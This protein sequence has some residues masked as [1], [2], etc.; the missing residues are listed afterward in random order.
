ME[1]AAAEQ[2]HLSKTAILIVDD[3]DQILEFIQGDLSDDYA[4]F[5]A[6]NGQGGVGVDKKKAFSLL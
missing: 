4:V 2:R 5:T 6:R 3:H 1:K